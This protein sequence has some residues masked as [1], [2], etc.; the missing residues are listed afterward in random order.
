MAVPAR[1]VHLPGTYFVTSRTW[2]SRKLFIKPPI[3]EIFMET[4]LHYRDQ[5]SYLLHA[6]VLMPDHFHVLLTPGPAIALERA[7]QFIKGGSARRICQRLNF[8]LPVWQR[9]FS[10]HRIRDAQDCETHLR[11]IEQNH[12]KRGLVSSASEYPW[13]SASG[14]FAMDEPPQ[15]LKPMTRTTLLGTVETVP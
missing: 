5:G 1:R 8:R 12:V 9:G 2:E 4:L 3:C 13:S 6:F 15:G 14:R 11:Y 7:V 10:D